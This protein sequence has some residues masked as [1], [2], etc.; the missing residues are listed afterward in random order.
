[1]SFD[2]ELKVVMAAALGLFTYL[3]V[4]SASMIAIETYIGRTAF[5]VAWMIVLLI[6][7]IFAICSFLCI[8]IYK[9][10]EKNFKEIKAH[11]TELSDLTLEYDKKRDERISV[12][13]V[14]ASSE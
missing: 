11:L 3:S 12:G 6:P 1:M 9:R 13:R 8:A 10:K 7:L 4:A 2:K 14:K 5:I